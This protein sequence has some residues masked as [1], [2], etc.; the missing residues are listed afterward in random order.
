MTDARSATFLISGF[1]LGGGA[2]TQ[3]ARVSRE[4]R[5]RGWRV[6][7]VE[8]TRSGALSSEIEGS[9]VRVTSLDFST[10]RPLRPFVELVSRLRNTR[11]Q[12][13]VCFMFHANLVGRLAG[14]LASVPVIVTSIRNENFGPR[15]REWAE[16]ATE[17]FG[18]AVTCNSAV[19][20]Q[21]LVRRG[22]VSAGR[23][24]VIPNCCDPPAQRPEGERERLRERLAPDDE[25]LWLSVG[26]LTPQK[27]RVGLV[28]AFARAFAQRPRVRLAIAGG[29]LEHDAILSAAR[30]AG[31]A[32][33]VELLGV[34]DDVPGLLG[35]ADA[36]VLSSLWEGSPNALIEAALAGVP[37]VSTDSG[38]VSEL[39]EDG[40]SGLLVPPAD[41]EALAEAMLRLAALPSEAR[42]RLGQ[43]A[44]ERLS[45]GVGVARVVDRWESLLIRLAAG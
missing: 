13:L 41:P 28:R 3:V 19:V 6:D 7:V 10:R 20:A 14:R 40:V 43:T 35:A 29:G 37:A 11:P 24:E 44:R 18:H 4:L 12:A 22:V 8:M 34:R 26:S 31:V 17:P 32:E 45:E 39:I 2:E 25:F 16:R 9:D 15:W 38:G 5:R 27:D 30:Q 23:I 42:H 1:A 21:G 33:R 36:F